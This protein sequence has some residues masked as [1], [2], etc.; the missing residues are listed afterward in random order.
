MGEA[1][2][3]HLMDTAP[4][5]IWCSGVHGQSTYFNKIWL[6][7]TGRSM[8]EE[9]QAG[10]RDGV[11]PEDYD[12]R[13]SLYADHF[14]RREPF[15]VEYRIRR[16]DGAW[17]WVLGTGVPRYDAAGLFEGF[18]GS[19]IDITEMKQAEARRQRDL[20]EKAALLQELHHR[21]KNNAQIFASLLSIQANRAGEPAVEAALRNA[22]SRAAALAITQ[23][24]IYD[25]GSLSDFDVGNFARRLA[26]VRGAAVGER[27]KIALKSPRSVKV[28]LAT[29]VPLG[30]ILNEL[31]T[32]AL[33][34]A[35]PEGRPGRIDIVLRRESE[36]RICV[37]VRDN[38]IGLPVGA[39][40][41]SHRSTGL[42]IVT[43]LAR[44]LGGTLSLDT[45]A[46]VTVCLLLPQPN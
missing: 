32:N 8:E 25:A 9:M 34:H 24:Q 44:Q 30:L 26:D 35:F 7:F 15:R 40:L 38:G 20:E 19:C 21:V 27:V 46:G 23:Q 22:A 18:I 31:L 6:D 11:H 16:K 39:T 13:M 41:E 28:P 10:W 12:R 29:A 2:F 42:T 43:S 33:R 5:M 17:R 4:V 14:L 45:D 36:G 37:T 1:R 3:H